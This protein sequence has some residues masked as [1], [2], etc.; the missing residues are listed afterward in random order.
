MNDELFLEFL[1][2]NPTA[3]TAAPNPLSPLF[4]YEALPDSSPLPPANP[5]SPA[6]TEPYSRPNSPAP[7][8]A[9]PAAAPSRAGGCKHWCF[10]VNNPTDDEFNHLGSICDPQEPGN[11]RYLVM[12][13][14]HPEAGTPHL[15]GYL[16]LLTRKRLQWLKDNV[17]DRAHWEGRH[18]TREAAR[19]YC[20]KDGEWLEVGEWHEEER[21]RRRDVET[22]VEQASQGTSFFDAC[23]D[24]PTTALFPYAYTKLLEG[25][26]RGETPP[27][28]DVITVVKI[29]P[30]GC[31]K[32]RDAY[33]CWPD[34][35]LQD[36]SAGSV[37][38]WDGYEGQRRLVLD[39]FD[40]CIPFRF[41]LR[42]LDGY[43]IRLPV[44]GGF[45]Y[46]VWTE[47]VVT[48]NVPVT[49]W[50]PKEA[51]ITPLWR[52]IHHIEQYNSCGVGYVEQY[53]AQYV[54]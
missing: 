47:V 48:T 29:G 13:R 28:R 15:Q 32:T 9:P 21:G 6:P 5:P 41:L 31:G 45:T 54:V 23:A 25:R 17:S 20:C 37:I 34:L 2:T 19:D 8:P 24:E 35:F 50:Y 14:E 4:C 26:A 10:T 30:T 53:H 51:D 49:R 12:G 36:C 27:W 42:L 52:R 18:G 46:G 40:G 33:S 1:A 3:Q 7:H 43:P 16:E 39:D 44:K 11:V 38:W 22:M